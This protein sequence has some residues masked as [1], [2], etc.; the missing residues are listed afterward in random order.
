MNI[1]HFIL[2]GHSFGGYIA[3]NYMA[4]YTNRVEQ[5]IFLSPAGMCVWPEEQ[6][7]AKKNGGNSY[8]GW[9]GKLGFNMNLRPTRMANIPCIGPI[10]VNKMLTG[11]LG[12]KDEK[13]IAAWK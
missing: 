8:F 1:N 13:E 4:R 7:E 12:F 10:G 3:A 5:L 9:T 11:K 6:I 2:V